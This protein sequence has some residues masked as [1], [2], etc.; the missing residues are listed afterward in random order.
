MDCNNSTTTG[1]NFEKFGTPIFSKT[2]PHICFEGILSFLHFSDSSM[3]DI[4]T[5]RLYKI[6]PEVERLTDKS[7]VVYIPKQKLLLD[8]GKLAWRG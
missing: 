7:S 8:E 4:S 3:Y 1:R 6:S 5:D 2:M